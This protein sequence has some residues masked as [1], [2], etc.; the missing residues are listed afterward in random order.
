MIKAS[1]FSSHIV[2]M[3]VFESGNLPKVNILVEGNSEVKTSKHWPK[4]TEILPFPQIR[5]QAYRL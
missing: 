1:Y 5:N 2:A 4:E 3:D